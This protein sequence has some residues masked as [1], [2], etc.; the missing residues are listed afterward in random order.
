MAD[1]VGARGRRGRRGEGMAGGSG[2][3]LCC[4]LRRSPL[5]QVQQPCVRA[6]HCTVHTR[7]LP[8]VKE[9]EAKCPPWLMKQVAEGP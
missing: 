9:A 3:L 7:P 2:R 1:A 8:S 6:P 4:G 5:P